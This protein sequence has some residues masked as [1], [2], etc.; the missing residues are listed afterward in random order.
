[1]TVTKPYSN[2]NRNF[3]LFL[4]AIFL[5]AAT[6]GTAS[7]QEETIRRVTV[8]GEGILHAEPDKATVY[9]GIVTRADDPE[10]ARRQ[11]AE[12][13]KRA[14]TAVR[15]L[16]IPEQKIQMQQLSLQPAR[17]YNPDTE[18]W[19]EVGFEVTRQLQVD[20]EDLERLPRLVTEIVQQGAN[21]LN[22]VE[23]GLQDR[24]SVR[25]QALQEAIGD[26]ETKAG[27]MAQ[28]AGAKLGSVMRIDEQT[29]DF[30]RPTV[31][32]HEMG[33]STAKDKAAPEPEAYAAGEIEVRA[34]VQVVYAL[35]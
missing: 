9:F 31:Q 8:Q 12:A 17:E 11:N 3:Q 14:L 27:L 15:A 35:E 30:P 7:A 10:T 19:E 34:V 1:M 24:S 4:V 21:R 29:V 16:D 13:S 20:V 26:A 6:F 2:M 25:N 32:M 5:T 28:T 22:R 18:R 33:R 23:Y